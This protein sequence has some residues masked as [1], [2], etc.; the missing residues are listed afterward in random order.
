M[1]SNGACVCRGGEGGGG[2]GE[3][4]RRMKDGEMVNEGGYLYEKEG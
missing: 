2:D 1:E 3:D 4:E